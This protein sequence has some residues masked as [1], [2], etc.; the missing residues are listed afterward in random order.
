MAASSIRFGA[1]C[2]KEVGMDFKNMG[3]KKVMIVTDSTVL[4]L[5]AMKQVQEGLDREGIKYEIYSNCRVE[6]KDHS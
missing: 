3:A 4:H 1:G 6:P 2:T 5:T